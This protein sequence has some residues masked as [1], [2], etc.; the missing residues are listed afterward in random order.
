MGGLQDTSGFISHW[1][2][3]VQ[4]EDLARFRAARGDPKRNTLWEALAVLVSLRAWHE[5]F[6]R[7]T[8]ASACSDNLGALAVIQQHATPS[9]DLNTVAQ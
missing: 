1:F 4:D 7:N 6:S 5:R 2:D 8:P 9:A 3:R